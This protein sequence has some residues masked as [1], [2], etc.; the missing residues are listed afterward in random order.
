M[1]AFI[2]PSFTIN[3]ESA[4]LLSDHFSRWQSKPADAVSKCPC[5]SLQLAWASQNTVAECTISS[6][7][8]VIN[9]TGEIWPSAPVTEL[10]MAKCLLTVHRGFG[11]KTMDRPLIKAKE[12][13]RCRSP[14]F[15]AHR[16]PIGGR[17][18]IV[19]VTEVNIWK[20]HAVRLFWEV[21]WGLLDA[22]SYKH[23]RREWKRFRG[24]GPCW[25]I[26]IIEL[27]ITT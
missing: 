22:V 3:L 27:K 2:T 7:G 15:S 1:N 12:I 4:S 25:S 10:R 26:F 18:D 6:R 14:A 9:L 5:H 23:G 16:S 21:N 24:P 11:A 19:H 8:H 17:G 13:R 20:G